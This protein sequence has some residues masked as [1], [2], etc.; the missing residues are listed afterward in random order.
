MTH[1][2]TII[3]LSRASICV[4]FLLASAT[5]HEESKPTLILISFD[6]FRWDYL[7]KVNTTTL[8]SLA[9]HGVSSSVVN[10]FVT[11]TFPNH[12]SIVTGRYEENHGIINNVMWDPLYKET[13][14]PSTVDPKWF[15]GSEPVWITNQRHGNGHLSA[16][17]N[18]VGGSVPYHGHTADFGPPYNK[19]ISFKTR[20]DMV[21]QQLDRDPPV[22]FVAVYFNEPDSSGHVY[23]PNSKEVVEAVKNLDQI[24]G[25]L[26]EELKKRHLYDQVC[27]RCFELNASNFQSDIFPTLPL[28]HLICCIIVSKCSYCI[29][30]VNIILTSDHGM[31]EVASNK[32]IFLDDYISADKYNLV[33]S[34]VNSFIIPH[35]GEEKNIYQNL[36]KAPHLTVF[37]KEDIPAYWHYANNRRVTPI[38]VTSDLGYRIFKNK[39]SI[40]GELG[41]HGYNNSIKE[42]HPFFI[43]HGPAFKQGF[44]SKPFSI[45]HIYPLM[46]YILGITPAPND[47]NLS[48]VSQLLHPHESTASSYV[49]VV[50]VMAIATLILIIMTYGLVKNHRKRNLFSRFEDLDI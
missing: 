43:A 35:E 50:I 23:G 4:L 44:Q 19:S 45:V 12:Y 20:V 33:D 6:G 11:R 8:S 3:A 10:N 15:N 41:A 24:A 47:G 5:G 29:L 31:A 46:C 39:G 22:N 48:A 40:K 49:L 16:V 38:F 32:I 1:E 42:M 36:T 2:R 18:W 28:S 27:I 34:D 26:V 21:L 9:K 14:T 37:Y 13:F 17:I 25:Y 30:Q 7:Q